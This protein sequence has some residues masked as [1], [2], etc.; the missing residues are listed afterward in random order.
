M[1]VCHCPPGTYYYVRKAVVILFP[2]YVLCCMFDVLEPPRPLVEHAWDDARTALG[3]GPKVFS[4][5]ELLAKGVGPRPMLRW[6][7]CTDQ[8]DHHLDD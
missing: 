5:P 7:C 1:L 4:A 8:T 6:E 3:W 2:A